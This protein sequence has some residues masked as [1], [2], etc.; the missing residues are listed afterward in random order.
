MLRAVLFDFDG[1][2]VDTT[3]LIYQSLRHA[4]R[5]VLGH[6][7]PR[8][9]LM[10]NV[11]QPLPVQMAVL[12]RNEGDGASDRDRL[13]GQLLET[14]RL[15]NDEH[16]EALI[17]EFPGV[18][19]S[20]ARLHRAGVG[21]GVVTSK[22]RRSVEMA[23]ETFP[24]LGR[25][26]DYFVTM[27]DTKEH[28]PRPAPLLKGLEVLG[29]VPVSEAAYVGDSPHD[30]QAARA[31]DLMSVAVSWGAFSEEALRDARPDYLVP[32]LDAAVDVLL[33]LAAR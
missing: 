15:H 19:A 29:D 23:L 1:T 27:E 31:A 24:G 12:A 9:T 14:Y 33:G 8:E 4:A 6:E 18:E 25:V 2:L 21:I 5:E 16:H 3:E 10:A 26:T 11:G 22:R 7:P 13:A 28:K 17:K 30:V 20:L 32:D